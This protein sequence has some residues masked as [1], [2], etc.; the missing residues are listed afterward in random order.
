[1]IFLYAFLAIYVLWIYYLAV[2]NLKRAIDAD[3][4]HPVAKWS[5]YLLVLPPAVLTDWAVNMTLCT[6][7]FLDMPAS[8][9]ELVTG[10]LKRYAESPGWHWR[11]AGAIWFA[12]SMLDV[13]DPSGDHV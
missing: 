8:K 7:L 10:R 4:A 1:M 13:F 6:F 12:T 5:G 3:L 11:K 2:M 9:R